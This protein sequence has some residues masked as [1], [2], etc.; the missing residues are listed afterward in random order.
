MK[1]KRYSSIEIAAKLRQAD[2]LAAQGKLQSEIAKVLGISVMT[3][4]RWR[5]AMKA[6]KPSEFLPV[7]LADMPELE[8]TAEAAPAEAHNGGNRVAELRLENARLRHLVADLL[9]E[10][11]ALE[12]KIGGVV[13]ERR[14]SGR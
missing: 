13:A 6:K 8:G 2:E 3:Y 4:H 10:K 1:K 11:V 14:S 12:E 9:L 7:A 5:K